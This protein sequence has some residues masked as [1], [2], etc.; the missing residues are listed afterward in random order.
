MFMAD[1]NVEY[2]EPN[3]IYELDLIPNDPRFDDQW[4]LHNTGQTGGTGDAD[5][6]APEAWD[7]EQGDPAVI[8]AITDT[9]VDYNH[10]DLRDN[11]WTN[12]GETPGDGVDNDGN[13]YVDDIHGYDFGNDDGDP[14]DDHNHGTHVAGTIGAVG[15]NNRGITGVNLQ[16]QL[17]ALKFIKPIKCGNFTIGTGGSNADAAEAIIYATDNNAKIINASWGGTSES[18]TLK[19]AITFADSGG[20]LFVAAAGNDGTDNDTEPHYPSNYGAPP[21]NLPNVIAVAA[22]D[23]NDDL[24]D[25]SNFGDVSVHLGAPGEDV[26]STIRDNDYDE[27]SGTS[28]AAPHVAGVA[29]LVWAHH[30]SFT[31]HQVKQCILGH[32]DVLPSLTG[33]VVTN[34]RL[35]ANSAVQCLTTRNTPDRP[36]LFAIQKKDGRSQTLRYVGR[37]KLKYQSDF[38]RVASYYGLL[39]LP[40]AFIFGWKTRIRKRKKGQ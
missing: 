39:C 35:N 2:V 40:I 36:S 31:H 23:H 38:M 37:L 33:K 21:H 18:A 11:M 30:P 5:I 1:P 13:G 27:F 7:I 28:M 9:G 10:E 34:G 3:Y 16:T 20:V 17:M 25:F 29:A 26:L 6:D 12:P 8:V 24:A 22:T 4:A 19:D 15:N 14:M 32:V